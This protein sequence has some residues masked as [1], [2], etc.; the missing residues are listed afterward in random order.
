MTMGESKPCPFC[1]K[2]PQVLRSS[3]TTDGVIDWEEFRLEHECGFLGWVITK[4][5]FSTEDDLIDAWNSR[6]S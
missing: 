2:T 4:K 6:L 3:C 1:G 5:A